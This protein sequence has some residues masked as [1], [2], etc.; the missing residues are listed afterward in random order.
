MGRVPSALSEGKEEVVQGV[1]ERLT[2]KMVYDT[3]KPLASMTD[4]NAV[5]NPVTSAQ[6]GVMGAA[7][8][9][10]LGGG[11]VATQSA[12]DS[13]L[14]Q[15]AQPVINDTQNTQDVALN[16]DSNTRHAVERVVGNQAAVETAQ[17]TN[18]NP[19]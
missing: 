3:D 15:K 9:G 14:Q 13:I 7:I 11:Q 18:K 10:I 17:S 4:P 16:T 6:E 12:I 1:I 8:G 19:L 2:N 5:F